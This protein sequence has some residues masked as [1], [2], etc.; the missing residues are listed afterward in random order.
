MSSGSIE[1]E[2]I[3]PFWLESACHGRS[4]FIY[5]LTMEYLVANPSENSVLTSYVDFFQTNPQ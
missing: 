4:P 1:G 5:A 2:T 3:M